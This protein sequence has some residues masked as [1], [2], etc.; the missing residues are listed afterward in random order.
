MP[1]SHNC[2]IDCRFFGGMSAKEKHRHFFRQLRKLRTLRFNEVI[3]PCIPS[4]MTFHFKEP[5]YLTATVSDFIIIFMLS[6]CYVCILINLMS[7]YFDFL[8]SI[9]SL[10]VL[11]SFLL[12]EKNKK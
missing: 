2:A 12:N 11:R 1:V 8:L 3:S 5:S 6:N 4:E 7:F 9:N 10:K